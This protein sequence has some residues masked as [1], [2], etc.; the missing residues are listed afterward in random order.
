VVLIDSPLQFYERIAYYTIAECCLVTAV[1][2]GMN[3]IPYEYIICRQGNEKLDET[4]GLN[5]S[6]PRKSMLVVSEFI[7][8]SPSLSGAIR[9]NPWNIDAVTEAMN[10][11]LIVPEPEKQMR[12]EKHHRYVSTHDVAYWA[13]SFLQDL[14]RACRD[15]VRRR[16]WGIGFGLGFRVIALDPNF[17]KLSV[18]H[19]VSA[20]KRTKNRAILLDYDGTMILPSSISRTPNM[21][22][23]GVLNSLC[24]DPKNV[25]FLVSGKDRETLTEWFSSCEKLGIAAEHGYFMRYELPLLTSFQFDLDLPT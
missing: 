3:L 11:A 5:P 1:R 6:A 17:R 13:H 19:I 24:T 18:E 12:H 20:Y 8:C 2:D 21:E 25:V 14:E 10:S 15:H 16:C 23:V 7:G 4:L 9:V 22:A